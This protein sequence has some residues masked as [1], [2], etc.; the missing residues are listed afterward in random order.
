MDN[1]FFISMANM[2]PKQEKRA[3]LTLSL[4]SR[5]HNEGAGKAA[6]MREAQKYVSPDVAT[7]IV[8]HTLASD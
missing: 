6:M 5:L 1:I 8:E 4:V 3:R 7:E 2:T